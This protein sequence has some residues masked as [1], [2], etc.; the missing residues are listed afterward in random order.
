[1]DSLLF[2]TI[3]IVFFALIFDFINGFHDTANTIA[4]SVSTRALSPR[5]AIVLAASMNFL[6]ALIFTGVA[7]TIG[8]GIINPF[9]KHIEHGTTIVMAALIAA[10]IWNLITW[11]YGIPSSSSNAIIGALA[12]AGITAIGFSGINYTGFI[13]IIEA[14]VI[15]PILALII[16]FILMTIVSVVFHGFP[17]SKTNRGFLLSIVIV[18]LELAVKQTTF[19][20]PSSCFA[21]P[22]GQQ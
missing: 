4:T 11:Y 6:G 8:T 16:G 9:D 20:Q 14:L 15:S 2:L 5:V 1:M 12:G 17:L 19:L 10:I 22:L 18:D 13:S 3:T 7:K 21:L